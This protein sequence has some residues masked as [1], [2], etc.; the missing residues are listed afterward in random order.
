MRQYQFKLKTTD[1]LLATDEWF[2]DRFIAAACLTLPN[3]YLAGYEPRKSP[4]TGRPVV[5]FHLTSNELTIRY[6]G[7]ERPYFPARVQ[8]FFDRD[9]TFRS[10]RV[11]TA[12]RSTSSWTSSQRQ[13]DLRR[14]R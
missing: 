1:R 3:V 9:R 14:T 2:T 11:T 7:D 4:V 12:T 13:F 5:A 8:Q 6:H 10:S